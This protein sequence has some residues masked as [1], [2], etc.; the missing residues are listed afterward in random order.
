MRRRGKLLIWLCLAALAVAAGALMPGLALDIQDRRLEEGV[1][2]AQVETVDLN[3][4]SELTPTE[5]LYLASHYDSYVVLERGRL[6][7]AQNAADAVTKN[8]TGLMQEGFGF[9]PSDVP[10]V[11]GVEPRL[12]MGENGENVVFWYAELGGRGAPMPLA[13]LYGEDI[14]RCP[15]TGSALLDER[16]GGI[17]ALDISWHPPEADTSLPQEAAPYD[18]T[19]TAL[20]IAGPYDSAETEAELEMPAEMPALDPDVLPTPPGPLSEEELAEFNEFEGLSYEVFWWLRNTLGGELDGYDVMPGL[21]RLTLPNGT[22]FE[23]A[24]SITMYSILF[25][26]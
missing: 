4:L 15:V 22:E 7:T 19:E 8:L 24:A 26:R 17:A 3:L 13:L 5:T 9:D 16:T 10:E 1:E 21:Y 23:V 2:S 6:M 18:G 12:Y 20:E 14:E 25:N 11:T